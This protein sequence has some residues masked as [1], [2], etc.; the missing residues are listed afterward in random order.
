MPIPCVLPH[1]QADCKRPAT[2]PQRPRPGSTHLHR[3]SSTGP[4]EAARGLPAPFR[5]QG[6][7]L[8]FQGGACWGKRGGDK[9]GPYSP[10]TPGCHANEAAGV[11]AG[12]GYQPRTNF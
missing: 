8:P 3:D 12:P 11:R 4:G 10:A 2:K 5:V 7:H 6:R 1:P 9:A